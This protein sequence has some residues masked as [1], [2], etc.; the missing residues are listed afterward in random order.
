MKFSKKFTA[1]SLALGMVFVSLFGGCTKNADS[2]VCKEI[3]KQ[4]FDYEMK[5]ADLDIENI[6]KSA[7]EV[8]NT[9]GEDGSFSDIDY[10]AK[11]QTNWKPAK[12]LTR[13]KKLCIAYVNP[14]GTFFENHD[15]YVK[16]VS[17]LKFWHKSNPT[18]TNWY[19]QEISSPQNLGCMLVLMR[20]GKEKVDEKTENAILKRMKRK[21]GNPKK[22]TGANK[23]DIALHY[24]YRGALTGDEKTVEFATQQA[25]STLQYTVDEGFQYDNSY[26]QHGPQLYITGYGNSIINAVAAIAAA[27]KGTAY[28][29]PKECMDV[30][31]G[32]VLESYMRVGRGSYRLYNTGG[33]SL[34][35]ENSLD[36]SGDT[37]LYEKLKI[38]DEENA[39]VY[40]GV[41]QRLSGE[42]SPDF[43]VERKN[44]HYWCSDYTL[45]TVPNF[46]FDVRTLSN[47]TY[48]NENGNKENLKGYF[49]ADGAYSIHVDGDEYFNIFPVWDF[50]LVP[51]TTTPHLTNIPVPKEWGTF[52][53]NTFAGGVSDGKCGISAYAYSDKDFGINTQANKSYFMIDDMI[54]CVGSNINSSNPSEIR[55]TLNQ[56]LADG[57][58]V[59]LEKSGNMKSISSLQ[60]FADI[61][62]VYHDKVGYV[63][64]DN[65]P[66]IAEKA[67]KKGTWTSISESEPNKSVVEKEVFTLSMSHGTKP[68]GGSYKYILLPG[69]ESAEKVKSFNEQSVEIVNEKAVHAVKTAD[70][71]EIYAVFFEK[72]T[73]KIGGAEI[74]VDNPCAVII[75]G[76]SLYISNPDQNVSSVNVTVKKGLMSKN[77]K[78][79]LNAFS[80]NNTQTKKD[81]GKTVKYDF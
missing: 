33:R 1:A 15:A 48:R 75:K 7:A 73:A 45:H 53:T 36:F 20:F 35:R 30:V 13:L 71:D 23:A 52:G 25:Y 77:I 24:V 50:S 9:I 76:N 18:S 10:K 51:G 42:K 38:I 46:T 68:S 81:A 70:G 67:L 2:E 40:D 59:A 43:L 14:K 12:H 16:I 29:M 58:A 22:W 79:Q 47:R 19:M 63:F 17:G 26:Q 11:D 32:F 61:K 57:D 34:A 60:Q 4:S 65:N 27:G 41:I 39:S 55:T 28:E 37:M 78:A 74:T 66:I 5:I 54:I 21:G 64:L 72:G 44:T 80:K 3:L 69:I 31:R 56:C 49:L 8:F 62:G 6:N